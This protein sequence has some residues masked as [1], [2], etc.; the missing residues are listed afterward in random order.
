MGLGNFM[1]GN[2]TA[3]QIGQNAINQFILQNLQALIASNPNFLINGIPNKF[4]TQMWMEPPKVMR[5][6]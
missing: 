4:L 5:L 1:A 2:A 6:S 3:S